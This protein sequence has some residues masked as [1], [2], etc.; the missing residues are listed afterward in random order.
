MNYVALERHPSIT[1][2][3]ERYLFNSESNVGEIATSGNQFVL[4]PLLTTGVPG[5]VNSAGA[6]FENPSC[7]RNALFVSVTIG[8]AYKTSENKHPALA[9]ALV[10]ISFFVL[11]D[12]FRAIA[13]SL[14]K[15]CCCFRIRSYYYNGNL[16]F[17]FRKVKYGQKLPNF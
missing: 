12:C 11:R 4:F 10:E 9:H 13:Y 1:W 2:S 7:I 17:E 8:V 3:Y 14:Q 16:P 6:C 15:R 5:S